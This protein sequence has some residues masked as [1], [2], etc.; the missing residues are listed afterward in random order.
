VNGHAPPFGG[1]QNYPQ[2]SN[3]PAAAVVAGT[4]MIQMTPDQ[5]YN[6]TTMHTMHQPLQH[7]PSIAGGLGSGLSGTSTRRQSGCL[8]LF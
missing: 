5:P 6:T 7:S 1:A 8:S 2:H 4:A 3:Y